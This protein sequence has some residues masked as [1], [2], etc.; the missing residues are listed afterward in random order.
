MHTLFPAQASSLKWPIFFLGLAL[1]GF[2]DGIL[3]HQILAWHHLL[4]NVDAASDMRTQLLADGAFHALMYVVAVTA[5]HR[6]WKRR[7]SIA[8]HSSGRALGG[9]ALLGFGSWHVIDAVFS[10]WITGIHRVRMDSPNPLVWDLIWFVAFGLAPMLVGWWLRGD[11][12][13]GQHGKG[14]GHAVAA[15]LTLAAVVA[16]PL[17]ALP[18]SNDGGQTLVMFAPGVSP[19]AAFDALAEADARVVWVD[20]S[21]G[22]WAVTLPD[23]GKVW[24]LHARGALLVSGSAVSLGCFSWSRAT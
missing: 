13:G 11:K 16:G 2:F 3:L 18:A 14:R 23:Q 21:G 9:W 17:A 5:L 1:G 20:A 4:S 10:H 19:G 6:I 22:L 15:S 8:A 12:P 7:A 24:R